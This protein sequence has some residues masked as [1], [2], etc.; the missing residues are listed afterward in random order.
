MAGGQTGW[1]RRTAGPAG[2]EKEAVEDI[3]PP[4]KKPTGAEIGGVDVLEIEEAA[5]ELWR[6]NIYAETGMGCEGPV[7]LVAAE[8]KEKAEAVLKEGGYI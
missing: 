1:D 6:H 4:P 3:Q 2:R 7:V 8:D 5:R